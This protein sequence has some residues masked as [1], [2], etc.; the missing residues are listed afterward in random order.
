MSNNQEQLHTSS[1]ESGNLFPEEFEMQWGTDDLP[2]GMKRKGSTHHRSHTGSAHHSTHHRS[3]R[4]HYRTSSDGRRH[5]SGSAGD[6]K[7]TFQDLLFADSTGEK[8]SSH[9]GTEKNEE[10]KWT[11][12]ENAAKDFFRNLK[13][14]LRKKEPVSDKA[15]KK[16]GE[17]IRHEIVPDPQ[18]SE[19]DYEA[20]EISVLRDNDTVDAVPEGSDTGASR[21]VLTGSFPA[22]FTVEVRLDSYDGVCVG[23]V[24][25]P[26]SGA[27]EL[28]IGLA[29][30]VTG[31]HAVYFAFETE[32]TAS[33]AVLDTFCFE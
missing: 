3:S 6:G 13:D 22:G 9:E 8:S 23:S 26:D 11:K 7:S 4:S 25:V 31:K 2:E 33:M 18:Q 20:E 24:T 5:S 14:D 29:A 30:A 27:S 16:P 21:A 32:D 15:G 19:T 1:S 28:E 10:N 12:K 17:D